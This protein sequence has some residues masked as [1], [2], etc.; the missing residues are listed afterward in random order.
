MTP[1]RGQPFDVEDVDDHAVVRVHST[2]YKRRIPRSHIE[3]G[4]ALGLRGEE[5]TPT[6]VRSGKASEFHPTYVAAILRSIKE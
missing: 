2:G 1:G 3:R 4:A 6:A 5:L